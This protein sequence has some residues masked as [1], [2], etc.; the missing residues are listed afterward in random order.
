MNST[1][2]AFSI[3]I[4]STLLPYFPNITYLVSGLNYRQMPMADFNCIDFL[5]QFRLFIINEMQ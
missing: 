4:Y 1:E 3:G 5:M 2:C